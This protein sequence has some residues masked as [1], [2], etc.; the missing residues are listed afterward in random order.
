MA[1]PEA[2]REA[3]HARVTAELAASVEQA[4]D[5]RDSFQ[6]SPD[7][8][9]VIDVHSPCGATRSSGRSPDAEEACLDAEKPST[10]WRFAESFGIAEKQA[11]TP[12]T[13]SP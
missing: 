5:E 4:H 6:T 8:L 10:D 12:S 7:E 1:I 9:P 2:A 3:V 13:A 11:N